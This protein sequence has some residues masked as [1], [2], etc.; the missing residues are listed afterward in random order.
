M[1]DEAKFFLTTSGWCRSIN[2]E[3]QILHKQS[4][5]NSFSLANVFFFFSLNLPEKPQSE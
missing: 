4:H 1:E 5:A 3:E 2:W